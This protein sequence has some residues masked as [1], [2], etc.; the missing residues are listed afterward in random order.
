LNLFA[1]LLWAGGFMAFIAGMPELSWA[2][3]LVIIIN[4]VFS[5]IQEYKA[6]RAVEALTKLLPLKV[7]AIRGGKST[8]TRPPSAG[9]LVELRR[10]PYRR[11]AGS[12]QPMS[13]R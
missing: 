13:S 9:D 11:T 1:A 2:I 10:G 6:E 3:F 12:S 5:F 7:K 4:A 8:S